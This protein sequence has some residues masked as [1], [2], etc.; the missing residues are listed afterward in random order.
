M[1]SGLLLEDAVLYNATKK[2]NNPI[3]KLFF[4]STMA[5][6]WVGIGGLAG[7]S[8]AG[9][10]PESVRNQWLALP[11]FL[12]GGFFAFGEPFNLAT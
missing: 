11:K 1:L 6:I 2:A 5:G 8:A 4:L 7:V 12:L 10:V 9:G 3:D